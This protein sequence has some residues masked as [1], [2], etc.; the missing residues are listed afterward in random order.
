MLESLWSNLAPFHEKT[1]FAFTT[2]IQL[3]I[4]WSIR[5][6]YRLFYCHNSE[7]EQL[8]PVCLRDFLAVERKDNIVCCLR[9]TLKLSHDN[10]YGVAPIHACSND[11]LCTRAD[12]PAKKSST[13]EDQ[14]VH[15]LAALFINY[16]RHQFAFIYFCS[17]RSDHDYLV[18]QNCVWLVKFGIPKVPGANA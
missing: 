17:K 12:F 10:K 8:L 16:F 14:K 9:F 3:R 5:P 1:A 7:L 4:L 2:R 11:S 18:E 15:V 6:G 13:F